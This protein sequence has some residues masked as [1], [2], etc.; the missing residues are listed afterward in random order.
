MNQAT[1]QLTSSS[2]KEKETLDVAKYLS[3]LYD[4]RWLIIACTCLAIIAGLVYTI[5]ATPIYR[6]NI[7][8]KVDPG[9]GRAKN[10]LGD[11]ASPSDMN[12]DIKS[13]VAAEME[14]LRSRAVVS[15]AVD[16][17]KFYIDVRPKYLPVFGRWLA[18]RNKGLS[19][20]GLLG[21]GGYVWGKEEATVS[22]FDVPEE[23]EGH[24]FTLK[25]LADGKYELTSPDHGVIGSGRVGVSQRFPFGD[26]SIVLMVDQLNAR[27][28]AEFTAIRYTRAD[29]IER[30]QEGLKISEKGKQSGIIEATLDGPNPHLTMRIL[31]GV[32]REYVR[33]N[34]YQKS[35]EAEKM[36]AFLNTQLPQLKQDLEQSESKYNS[37][38]NSRGTVDL[39]EEAKSMLQQS[40]YTQTKMVELRQRKEELLNRFEETHPAVETINQQMR[41]L[42][43]DLATV[44]A[45]IKRLPEVE[46]NVVRLNRDVR[47]NTELYTSLLSTAQQLRVASESKVGT[48]RLLDSAVVPHKP[49]KPKG[50]LILGA[51]GIGGILLGILAAI[52]R[53]TLYRQIDAPQDIEQLLGMPVAANI[54]H[55]MVSPKLIGR[56]N[57]R[58]PILPL[59]D[60][61][62]DTAESLRRF[63]NFLQH[64]MV[65]AK[66]N[67]I[68]ITGATS[69]VGKSFVSANFAVVLASIGKKVLVVDSDLRSGHLH[70]YFGVRREGGLADV[71]TGKTMLNHAIHHDV[72]EN[73]DFIA[74][75]SPTDKPAELLANEN[76]G[77]LLQLLSTRYDYV[78]IDTA[79][80]LEVSDAL[81][82]APHAGAIYNI[83]R[84]GKSTAHEVEEATKYLNQAGHTV[85]GLVLNDSKAR[86]SR[87]GYGGAYA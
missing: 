61:A 46:Q 72:A 84:G 78:L 23:L 24:A 34:V 59:N 22:Q 25:A 66:S 83:V 73:V 42:K 85:T 32:S 4:S 11:L 36:L 27:P 33:Q 44:D 86:H 64:S 29:T 75:G 67:I 54:P 63:R 82:V 15:K 81:S 31:D 39:G 8:I 13:A 10:V 19:E 2:P 76:Y 1:L 79:P 38:R 40:V 62:N 56:S 30:L 45:R 21:Y 51:A 18:K 35:E 55:S 43:R 60:A 70:H 65:N 47:I 9:T 74:N 68:M 69:G 48:A 12:F 14:V 50:A 28:E 77:K 80:I 17:G 87:Y 49:V 3:V 53:K 6:A 37:L 58:P 16:A 5:S 20:P 26:K 57:S 7:L 41:E 52:G 71:V